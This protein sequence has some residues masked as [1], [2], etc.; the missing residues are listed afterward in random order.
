[1][2]ARRMAAGVFAAVVALG[3][4]TPTDMR[5]ASPLTI[6]APVPLSPDAPDP[7]G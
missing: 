6:A 7:P 5:S 3:V 2:I 1:M 4:A